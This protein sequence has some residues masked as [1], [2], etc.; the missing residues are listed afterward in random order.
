LRRDFRLERK[1]MRREVSSFEAN[2]ALVNVR[3][4]LGLGRFVY[5]F[6][7]LKKDF[8]LVLLEYE[9]ATG[10]KLVTCPSSLGSSSL[11]R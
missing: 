8:W 5:Q 10:V 2:L 7:P 4:I 3:V 6:D 1:K 9:Y 11:D